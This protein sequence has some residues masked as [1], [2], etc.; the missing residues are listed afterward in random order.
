[1]FEILKQFLKIVMAGLVSLLVLTLVT[2]VYN[3]TGIHIK[4]P[5]GATDYKWESRQLKSNMT[6]GFSHFR[7][8]DNGFNNTEHDFIKKEPDIL[9]MG[10]SHM[11]A[12]LYK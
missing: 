5:Y 3:F 9:L 2:Y 1:M 8:D 11:E 12:V 4:N 7:M 10:S 6:E